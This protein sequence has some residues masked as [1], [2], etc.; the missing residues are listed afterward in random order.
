VPLLKKGAI[1]GSD[2]TGEGYQSPL[3]A[4]CRTMPSLRQ[5][6]PDVL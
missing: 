1:V 4:Q 6:Q 3:A 5:R 2:V